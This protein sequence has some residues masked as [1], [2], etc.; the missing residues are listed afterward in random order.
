MRSLYK[1]YFGAVVNHDDQYTNVLKEIKIQKKNYRII[2]CS[3]KENSNELLVWFHGGSFIQE[4]YENIL[5]FLVEISKSTKI[6]VLTFDYPLLY[7]AKLHET[8][9]FCN[10][11]LLD[12]FSENQQYKSIFYGGDSAGTYLALKVIE[13]ELNDSLQNITKSTA[14]GVIPNGFIGICGFYDATFG[15]KPIVSSLVNNWLWRVPKLTNFNNCILTIPAL[16]IT[17]SR[18]FLATQSKR[19]IDSQPRRLI[20]FKQF[21]TPNT[22]HCFVANTTLSETQEAIDLIQE[23][24]VDHATTS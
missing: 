6:D 11:I 2:K 20:K 10:R 5:P 15:G 16:I 3:S 14:I 8:L 7:T 17:S 12:F 19:F 4:K 23:F 18:D 9:N 22:L 24:F 13:T 21:V 1:K